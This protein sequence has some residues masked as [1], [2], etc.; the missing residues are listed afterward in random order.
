M[1]TKATLAEQVRK[2]IIYTPINPCYRDF[3]FYNHL[4][5]DFG[6]D[7]VDKEIDRQ[8]KGLDK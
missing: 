1:K 7:N 6:K 5:A 4:C 3:V 8:V 2:L